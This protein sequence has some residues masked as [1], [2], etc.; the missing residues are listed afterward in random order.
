ML[1]VIEQRKGKK[2]DTK[3]L[4]VWLHGLGAISNDF[5][6]LVSELHLNGNEEVKL[7]FPQAPN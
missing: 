5:Q 1:E 3:V 4:I 7:I 6:F 2:A